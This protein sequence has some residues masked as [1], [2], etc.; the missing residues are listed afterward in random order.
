MKILEC[1]KG[2]GIFS[3]IAESRGH[4]SFTIDIEE[5]YNPNLCKNILDVEKDDIPFI[6][7]VVI[8]APPCTQYSH[9]KRDGKRDLELADKIVKKNLEIISWFPNSMWIL[10]NPQT[11]LLKSRGFMENI[12][13]FDVDYCKYGK[14]YRKRTRIWTN[15]IDWKPRPLCKQDCGFMKGN[16]HIHSV[17]NNREKWTEK[18]YN[19]A[20]D[21]FGFPKELCLD[22]IKTMEKVVGF[23]SESKKLS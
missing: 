14:P 7:D 8:C 10:E 15:L 1:E 16:K 22:I 17:G 12:P 4:S 3:E 20:K 13:Y 5:K 6:P 19:K 9:A 11:G 23:T 2:S 21:K 18:K